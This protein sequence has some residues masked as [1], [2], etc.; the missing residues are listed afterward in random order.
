MVK[1]VKICAECWEKEETTTTVKK[2]EKY[3]FF[4][5]YWIGVYANSLKEAQQKIKEIIK[6]KGN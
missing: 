6:R 4:P 1:K 3:Y 5:S 2:K